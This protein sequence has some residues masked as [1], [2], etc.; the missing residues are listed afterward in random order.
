MQN[1]RV[2]QWTCLLVWVLAAMMLCAC[3]DEGEDE[4]ADGDAGPIAGNV[5]LSDENRNFQ[6]PHV[7]DLNGQSTILF[8]D[9]NG[10]FAYR[11]NAGDLIPIDTLG[12]TA[13]GYGVNQYV[14]DDNYFVWNTRTTSSYRYQWAVSTTRDAQTGPLV[15][16]MCI[17]TDQLNQKAFVAVK[18]S[19]DMFQIALSNFSD[20]SE[21][22]PIRLLDPDQTST[23]VQI[24]AFSCEGGRGFVGSADGRLFE[25]NLLDSTPTLT[26]L[27]E[28]DDSYFAMLQFSD[29][30]LVWINSNND[31]WLYNTETQDGPRLAVDVDPVNR[32]TSRVEDLRIFG[33]VVVWSDDSEG[34]YN[35]W[36]A[37]LETITDPAIYPQITNEPNDQR[38]P[39]IYQQKV[40]WQ[41]NRNGNWEVFSGILSTL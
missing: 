20:T 5:V 6:V 37:D 17:I 25:V 15:P 28:V 35:I 23:P 12:S 22:D 31:I 18:E 9:V 4:A 2:K 11:M 30:Y 16:G 8:R 38:F 36:A 21:L 1:K 27:F 33:S 7:F 39:Y 3:S 26:P 40:Y 19:G 10:I 24:Q 29:P 13:L 32:T 14:V 41:D 34:N